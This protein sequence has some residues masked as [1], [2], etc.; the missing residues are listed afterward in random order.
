MNPSN[1]SSHLNS[2]NESTMIEDEYDDNIRVEQNDMDCTIQKISDNI[3]VKRILQ[4]P[5]NLEALTNF[6]FRTSLLFQ[7]NP[8][9]KLKRLQYASECLLGR[10][11]SYSIKDSEITPDTM[12]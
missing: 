3:D 4:T 5:E 12:W 8:K 9:D 6:L 1:A 7:K 11:I 2:M 10:N